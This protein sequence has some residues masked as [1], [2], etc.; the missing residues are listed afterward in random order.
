[1][2]SNILIT[3]G[4]S[5]F[6]KY[7]FENYPHLSMNI[8]RND[9]PLEVIEHTVDRL[10]KIDGFVHFAGIAYTEP[11]QLFSREKFE[12][13][14]WANVGL[15][16]EIIKHLVKKKYSDN[17]NIVLFGSV[18]GISG[19]AGVSQYAAS[20]AAVIGMTRSLA[21]ELAPKGIRVNCISP[22]H[23]DG[24]RMAKE[25]RERVGAERFKKIDERHVLGPG[26]IKDAYDMTCYL[27]N[28]SRW[29]TGQNFVVD[30]GYT[31]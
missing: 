17:L 22:G 29:I 11:V 1:M 9:D 21:L 16:L 6:G 30:G 19:G 15:A 23:I 14:M 8:G 7:F 31:I 18:N 2:K 5:G 13:I 20:K 24:T 25:G 26:R 27:L 28:N 10:G 3:G 4:T 12:R